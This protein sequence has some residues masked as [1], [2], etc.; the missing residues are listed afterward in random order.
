[1]IQYILQIPA[2]SA[3]LIALI[4][5]YIQICTALKLS[6]HE[7]TKKLENSSNKKTVK[8]HFAVSAS[9]ELFIYHGVNFFDHQGFM[10]FGFV[11]CSAFSNYFKLLH[12]I[13]LSF[14][15]TAFSY[16]RM[17]FDALLSDLETFK[18]FP[19]LILKCLAD[20]LMYV[21]FTSPKQVNL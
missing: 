13:R 10:D 2:F 17:F 20:V 1:M 8:L 21:T 3:L 6:L 14:A 15:Q 11:G 7:N 16:T 12:V 4:R 18:C 5:S 19:A 9:I